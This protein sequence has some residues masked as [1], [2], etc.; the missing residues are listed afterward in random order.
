[1]DEVDEFMTE[2]IIVWVAIPFLLLLLCYG[3]GLAF[4]LMIRRPLNSALATVIGFLMMTIL[5]S[6]MTMSREVAPYTALIFGAMSIAGF[7]ACAIWFRTYIRLDHVPTLAGILTYIGFSL[8]V[9][10]SGNPSWAGW[11]K[12]DDTATWFAITDRIINVGQSIPSSVASTFDRVIAVY[13]GGNQFNYGQ[14]NSGKFSY[15]LGSFI[16]FGAISK[17]TG[18]EKAW[19]FQPYLALMAGLGAMIFALILRTHLTNRVLLVAISSVSMM[20][21]TIYSYAMWGGLKEVIL[22]IPLAAFA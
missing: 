20:A 15:P 14:L 17:L 18:V 13:L 7:F 8:P 19:I 16:P 2:M 10:A 5:G 1:M 11:V 9:A 21:S 12:L 3:L 22:V 6:L 4:S